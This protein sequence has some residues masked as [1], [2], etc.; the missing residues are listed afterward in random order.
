M[1]KILKWSTFVITHAYQ[2][3]WSDVASLNDPD[4]LIPKNLHV[5][6]ISNG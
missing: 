6:L 1:L 5:W 2:L 4:L 3:G